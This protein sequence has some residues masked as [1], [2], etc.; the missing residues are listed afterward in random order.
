MANATAKGKGAIWFK[1]FDQAYTGGKW[2]TDVIQAN[3]YNY[4]LTIPDWVPSGF[5]TLRTEIIDLSSNTKASPP[6]FT[7]APQFY[8]NCMLVNV[9]SDATAAPTGYKIPGIYNN[10][11]SKFIV[12]V[13]DPAS[14]SAFAIPGP[15][16]VVPKAAT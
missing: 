1:I 12:S 15:K 14:S 4:D 10:M 11:E 16:V 2:C 13:T 7:R 8:S 9:T 5:Y 3:S 6:D